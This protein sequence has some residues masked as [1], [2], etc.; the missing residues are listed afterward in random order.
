MRRR[1]PLVQRPLGLIS[2]VHLGQS[3]VIATVSEQ[4]ARRVF[5]TFRTLPWHVRLLWLV[6]AFVTLNVAAR[7]IA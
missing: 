4:M 7:L 1:E 5:R 2:M 6:A 3:I